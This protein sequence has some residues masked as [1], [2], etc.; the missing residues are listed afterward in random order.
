MPSCKKDF[1]VEERESHDGCLASVKQ[2]I[3]VVYF[4]T[5]K[6]ERGEMVIAKGYDG[7]LYRLV[8]SLKY[9]NTLPTEPQ[10]RKETPTKTTIP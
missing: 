6:D 9:M 8:K 3:S 2:Q 7:S 1:I 5:L 10:Q 4:F